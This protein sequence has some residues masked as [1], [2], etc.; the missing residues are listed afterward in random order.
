[1]LKNWKKLKRTKHRHEW[2]HYG[3]G[4]LRVTVERGN[5][6]YTASVEY[7]NKKRNI[8]RKNVSEK[9]ANKIALKFLNNH[10]LNDWK[11][12]GVWYR[13]NSKRTL[14]NLPSWRNPVTGTLVV[15]IEQKEYGNTVMRKGRAIIKEG[16]KRKKR[17]YNP[18]IEGE[19]TYSFKYKKKLFKW[20]RNHPQV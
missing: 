13:R 6:G 16:S 3:L 17:K 18:I 11:N 20:F 12:K 4:K 1:M 8:S 9:Q 2:R 10:P 5:N 7:K 19:D 14:T 15:L